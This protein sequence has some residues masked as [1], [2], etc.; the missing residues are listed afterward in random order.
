MLDTIGLVRSVKVSPDN[1][2]IFAL[3]E[4]MWGQH[5]RLEVFERTGRLSYERIYDIV[6]TDAFIMAATTE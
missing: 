5:G 4:E 1:R 2:Y 3:G 6:L